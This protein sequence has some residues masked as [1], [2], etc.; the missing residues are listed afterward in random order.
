MAKRKLSPRQEYRLAK[1]WGAYALFKRIEA[2]PIVDLGCETGL[3][4]WDLCYRVREH[5]NTLIGVDIWRPAAEEAQK[6]CVYDLVLCMDAIGFLQTCAVPP[7]FVLCAELIEHYTQE[8]G[9]ELL[10]LI[11]Q[12]P[13]AVLTTPI[14]LMPQ[15]EIEGNPFQRHRSGWVPRDFKARGWRIF[16]VSEEHNLIVAIWERE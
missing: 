15:G 8:D 1:Q 14:G 3:S 9:Y 2:G 12:S 5:H 6:S 13:A 16:D 7:A 4:G 10:D 11:E